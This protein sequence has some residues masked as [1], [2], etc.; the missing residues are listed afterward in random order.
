MKKQHTKESQG[1]DF[2]EWALKREKYDKRL[3][4]DVTTGAVLLDKLSTVQW[5]LE[6]LHKKMDIVYEYLTNK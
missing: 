1:K 6:K 3:D 4:V 5:E 2:L